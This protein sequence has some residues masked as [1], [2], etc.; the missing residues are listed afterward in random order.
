MT[1]LFL[2][3]QIPLRAIG[4]GPYQGNHDFFILVFSPGSKKVVNDQGSRIQVRPDPDVIKF[5]LRGNWCT[6]YSRQHFR[7][8][9]CI[10]H[11]F[12]ESECRITGGLDASG[13]PSRLVGS[14]DI[15]ALY[16]LSPIAV[17]DAGHPQ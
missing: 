3:F 12:L 14:S 1:L 11:V 2:A 17:C 15:Y 7:G 9:I 8:F 16:M 5:P 13:V 4:L 6:A 10:M